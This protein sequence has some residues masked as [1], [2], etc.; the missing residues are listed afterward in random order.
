SAGG[1]CLAGTPPDAAGEPV[2]AGETAEAFEAAGDAGDGAAGGGEGAVGLLAGGG[3]GAADRDQRVAQVFEPAETSLE[4]G[5]QGSGVD[6]DSG[7]RWRTVLET[8]EDLERQAGLPGQPPGVSGRRAA[9]RGPGGQLDQEPACRALMIVELGGGFA[10]PLAEAGGLEAIEM[11]GVLGGGEVALGGG[12]L[13][14]EMVEE[15]AVARRR[16]PS[17]CA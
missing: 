17:D 4:P 16:S 15:K 12:E 7:D 10:A 5:G 3:G 14:V 8:L 2:H 6:L 13:G 11:I 9:E 1:W